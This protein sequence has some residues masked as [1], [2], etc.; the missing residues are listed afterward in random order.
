M[1]QSAIVEGL[2]ANGDAMVRVY[3]KS[4]CAHDCSE[5]AGICGAKKTIT[6][7]AR[8]PLRARPGDL[9]TVETLTKRIIQAA[10]LVYLLPLAVLL[11]S[12]ILGY[13]LG[14]SET[15]Q[16]LAGVGGL[17]LGCACAAAVNRFIRRDRPLEYTIVNIDE[18][19]EE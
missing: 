18:E 8:N 3:Q 13:V 5:C 9:V 4:A 10:A 12:C 15:V 11:L 19:Q 7:Q 14:G 6:V 17:V 16:A 1:T 2:T